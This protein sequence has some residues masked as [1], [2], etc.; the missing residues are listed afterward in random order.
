MERCGDRGRDCIE[1]DNISIVC[2]FFN[3]GLDHESGFFIATPRTPLSIYLKT[4]TMQ[5]TSLYLPEDCNKAGHLSLSLPED[6][7]KAGHLSL[8]T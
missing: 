2:F 8:S 5:D 6:C 4:V 7:Q 3:K 1:G